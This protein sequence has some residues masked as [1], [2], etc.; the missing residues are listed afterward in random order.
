MFKWDKIYENLQQELKL[1]IF[2]LGVICL[3]RIGFIAVLHSFL[4]ETTTLKDIWTALYYGLRI[5]L[6]SVGLL[7]AASFGACVL[8]FFVR[9]EKCHTLRLIIGSLY[10]GILSLLF[11]ARIPY[12]EQFHMAFNQ[13]LFNTFHDDVYALFITLVQ[14]YHLPL[15]LLLA[16]GTAWI[17]IKLLKLWLNLRILHLPKFSHWYQNAVVRVAFLLVIYQLTIFVRYGGSMT[18]AYEI[19]W[20]NSGVTK[21]VLL[22]EA[23][24][25]DVQALY[26]AYQ[27]HERLE[28]SVGLTVN[29]EKIQEYGAYLAG[30]QLESNNLDDYLR[31][32]AQGGLTVKPKHVFLIISESYANWPLLPEYKDLNIANGMKGIIAQEEAAY[33]PTFLPNGMSTISGVMGVLTGFT[34]ANMYLNNLP[35]T[36][37]GAYSTAIAPQMEKLGYHSRFW[38]AGPASWERIRD[39]TLA[40]GFKEFYGIGD[41]PYETGSVWG[42]DDEYLFNAVLH[43]TREDATS[44]DVILSVSNHSPYIMDLA[45]KGFNPD[46]VRDGLSD[47]QK[48][49]GWLIQQLGHY[50]YADKMMAQFISNTRKKYPDSLFI[51]VGDHADR[52]NIETNPGLY[53]RYGIPMIVYG[54]GVTKDIFPGK[55]SGS[56]I[57]VAPTLLELVAPEGFE[58]YSIGHSLTRGNNFG[59]NYGFWI[60]NGYIGKTD[61]FFN[62]EPI[63]P[64]PGP[65]PD[66]DK[67]EKDVTSHRALSWWK[68]K[69]GNKLDVNV[70]QQ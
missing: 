44:F 48:E 35:Q 51:V 11:Y 12:Y 49:D 8:F 31:K 36:Y 33:V 61:Q 54:Q 9:Q 32:T 39:F 46:N 55:V 1:F 58:Y 17:L 14:Q 3:F 57:N 60:T 5:S 41:I 53:K 64:D 10:I 24:L 66:G 27:L 15:L 2:M 4:G 43:N 26:R 67:V 38:Y 56:H 47:K 22:N 42:C 19:D 62:A 34:D 50:W 7:A 70:A 20:E 29:S 52:L 40:Q 18:Y 28:S 30:T 25:D 45:A 63:G 65:L 6:K 21:D 59:V 68:I 23:I 16:A 13:L 69:Y 37:Q